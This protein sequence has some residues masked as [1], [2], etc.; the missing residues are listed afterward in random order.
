[1]VQKLDILLYFFSVDQCA[2][3]YLTFFIYLY[4]HEAIFLDLLL[5][6]C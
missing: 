2:Y 5:D 1:M 3:K 4:G 6:A